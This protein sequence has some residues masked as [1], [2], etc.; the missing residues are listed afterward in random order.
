MYDHPYRLERYVTHSH[1]GQSIVQTYVIARTGEGEI[2]RGEN[3]NEMRR[4]VD[5]ANEAALQEMG[6]RGR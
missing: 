1:T 2:C 4:L 3:F 5:A 6:D